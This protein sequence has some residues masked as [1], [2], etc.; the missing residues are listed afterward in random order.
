MSNAPYS[1]RVPGRRTHRRPLETRHCRFGAAAGRAVTRRR[2]NDASC[3]PMA[4]RAGN[5][6][7]GAPS[8]SSRVPIRYNSTAGRSS[9]DAIA[10]AIST[11]RR[12]MAAMS[13]RVTPRSSATATALASKRGSSA[14]P[15]SPGSRRS[16]APCVQLRDTTAVHMLRITPRVS[17]ARIAGPESTHP[18]S[19]SSRAVSSSQLYSVVDRQS[20][21]QA[22]RTQLR[23]RSPAVRRRGCRFLVGMHDKVPE[24]VRRIKAR[25]RSMRSRRRTRRL[26]AV[27]GKSMRRRKTL[28]V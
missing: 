19:T 28:L 26:R 15:S 20:A 8:A 17:A 16:P 23:R 9:T 21:P 10:S 11:G 1:S 25:G 14:S 12:A 22:S 4:S 24:L 5:S 2:P 7:R 18:R 13:S 3:T 27:T 6:W